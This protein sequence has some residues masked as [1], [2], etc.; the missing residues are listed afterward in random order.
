MFTLPQNL[1]YYQIGFNYKSGK[2]RPLTKDKLLIYNRLVVLF[3]IKNNQA[4]RNRDPTDIHAY[5]LLSITLIMNSVGLC[6][7]NI[8]KR[9]L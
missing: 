7:F 1:N 9:Y 5:A 3:F 6:I 4:K 8:L 2:K